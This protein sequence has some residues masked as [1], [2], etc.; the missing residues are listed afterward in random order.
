MKLAG[1]QFIYELHSRFC[2][3]LFQLKSLLNLLQ[4]FFWILSQLYE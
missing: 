2:G 4:R 1:V 3:S